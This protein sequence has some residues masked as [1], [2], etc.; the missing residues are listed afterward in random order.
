MTPDSCV[1]LFFLN[2]FLL[3]GKYFEVNISKTKLSAPPFPPHS[4]PPPPGQ[5]T[6][7]Y[8]FSYSKW[9]IIAVTAQTPNPRVNSAFLFFSWQPTSNLSGNPGAPSWI[10]NQN[11][12][13]SYQP[14]WPKPSS[15]LFWVAALTSHLVSGF[16]AS[17]STSTPTPCSQAFS[18]PRISHS[19]SS[20]LK[21]PPITYLLK[22][23][24]SFFNFSICSEQ[25]PQ[26]LQFPKRPYYTISFPVVP[27]PL[28]SRPGRNDLTSGPMLYCF[29]CW[30]CS[31]HWCLWSSLFHISQSLFSGYLFGE[32]F[33]IL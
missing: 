32:T 6:S 14:H 29:L 12:T 5:T 30:K 1:Q 13:T 3:S 11:L 33:L 22:N 16:P 27:F 9:N 31:S 23:T 4:A 15:C 26:S 24:W 19:Q 2:L 21:T 20:K 25:K 7:P 18:S 10:Y 28:T 8:N 17:T